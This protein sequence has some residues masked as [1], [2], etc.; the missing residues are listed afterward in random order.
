MTQIS[1]RLASQTRMAIVLLACT[2]NPLALA[3][4]E[5]IVAT[6]GERADVGI[7]NDS[8]GFMYHFDVSPNGEWWAGHFETDDGLD[9]FHLRGQDTTSFDIVWMEG[10]PAPGGLTGQIGATP[11][12][13]QVDINDIGNV[14]GFA[15]TRE[16]GITLGEVVYRYDGASINVIAATGQAIPALPGATYGADFLSPNIAANGILSFYAENISGAGI[17]TAN[18]ALTVSGNGNVLAGQQKGVT[19]YA[20]A[21]LTRIDPDKFVATGVDDRFIFAGDT[22]ASTATDDLVVVGTLGSAGD[23]VLQEGVTPVTT[24][25]GAELFDVA[26]HVVLGGTAW[27]AAGDTVGGTGVVLR[28]GVVIASEGDTAPNGFGYVGDPIALAADQADNYAWVWRTD[29]PDPE[30]DLVLVYNGT[31]VVI[32][33]HD[34]LM[35]DVDADGTAD[36]VRMDRLFEDFFDL[37]L[38]SG[39]I[40]F[41]TE[42]DDP[43]T[44]VFAGYAFLRVPVSADE[45]GDGVVDSD[46]NCIE[47]ANADQRDTDSDGFGNA[48]DP[49]LNN[50][51]TIN[52]IDLGLLRSVFFS[53]DANADFNGDGVVNVIDLGVM[54]ATFFGTPGPSGVE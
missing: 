4:I 2:M 20:G 11:T 19:S 50:D 40:Y 21:P 47:I 45:D 54:R 53:S 35:Y 18:D 22:S 17:S 37:E 26:S 27:F 3:Q 7:A 42:L 32:V 25:G 30:R 13:R 6:T 36:E 8:V 43:V 31:S 1:D 44:T 51:G 5:V 41:M 29:N 24:S 49:D 33:E 10:Q 15:R 34:T 12:L 14:A 52:V 38:A 16:S 28:D 23:I 39:H 48:C 9:E 46:D